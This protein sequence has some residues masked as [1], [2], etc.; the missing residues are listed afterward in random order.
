[1][2]LIFDVT[3]LVRRGHLA[4]P[5]GIDRVE[6]AY[7]SFLMAADAIEPSFE[8][9]VPPGHWVALSRAAVARLLQAQ[10]LRWSGAVGKASPLS[11]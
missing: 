10:R 8:A 2:H 3:R 9:F 11:V 5:T 1:M 4:A 7:L 6:Q